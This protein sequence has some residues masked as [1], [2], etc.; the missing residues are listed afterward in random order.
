MDTVGYCLAVLLVVLVPPIVVFWCAVH[1][2]AAVWRRVGPWVAYSLLFGV[3]CVLG[4]GCFLVRGVLMGQDLGTHP[5]PIVL[6]LLFYF[7]SIALENKVR[8][9]LTFKALVG[10]PELA[11]DRMESKLLKEGIYARVRHPRY[12]SV[13]VGIMGFALLTNYSGVY[14]VV[15]LTPLALYLIT[16]L[17]ERE[18]LARFGEEYRQY[19]EG[20]PRFFPRLTS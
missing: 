4:W 3:V 12:A 18:L 20:V 5:L 11:P 13:I 14:V 15:A 16:V 7:A 19:R 2:L 9:Q 8:K 6:G 17:E 1:P 10:L